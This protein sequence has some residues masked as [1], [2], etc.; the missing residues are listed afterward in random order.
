MAA[1]RKILSL[2]GLARRA[3][4]TESGGF[5]AERAVR[6]GRASLVIVSADAA[7]N[8]AKSLRNL[9]QYYRVPLFFGFGKEELGHAMGQEERAAVAVTDPGFSKRLE[10]LLAQ[11]GI[12]PEKRTEEHD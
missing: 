4:K 2:L 10:T 3:G 8:T 5:L 6:D 1:T 7:P 11:G 9:C 12:L